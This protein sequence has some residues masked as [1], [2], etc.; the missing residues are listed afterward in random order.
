MGKKAVL[1]ITKEREVRHQE[2]VSDLLTS[3]GIFCKIRIDKVKEKRFSVVS[4]D[5]MELYIYGRN[6]KASEGSFK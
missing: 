6:K 5:R 2:P 3:S 1:R 4:Y